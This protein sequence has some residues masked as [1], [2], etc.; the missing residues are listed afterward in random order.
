MTKQFTNKISLI[1]L[2]VSKYVCPREINDVIIPRY[3][4][5]VGTEWS[6]SLTN[7]QKTKIYFLHVVRNSPDRSKSQITA[8]KLR[9]VPPAVSKQKMEK[10]WKH[11]IYTV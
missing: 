10:K 8:F 11:S 4:I 2:P 7:I 3:K 1:I 9:T 5:T 6:V